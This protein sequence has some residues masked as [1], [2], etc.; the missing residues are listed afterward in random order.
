MDKRRK[1]SSS[2]RFISN[3]IITSKE[4]LRRYPNYAGDFI[5]EIKKLYDKV[6]KVKAKLSIVYLI[7]QYCMEVE[8][9]PYLIEHFIEGY[10]NHDIE[11]KLE[12]L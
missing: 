8:D 12:V 10:E 9:S 4:L 6:K 11:L 1:Y 3:D 7:A 2:C 5:P